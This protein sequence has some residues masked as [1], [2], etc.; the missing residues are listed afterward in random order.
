M[1]KS[2]KRGPVPDL[3]VSPA[4]EALRALAATPHADAELL[5][6]CDRLMVLWE[7]SHKRFRGDQRKWLAW[8]RETKPE[9]ERLEVLVA[10]TPART[11]DG[12][13]AKVELALATTP[14][15]K[16]DGVSIWCVPRSALIDALAGM[17]GWEDETAT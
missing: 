11:S 5:V 12:R 7:A 17:P 16:P 1:A 14:G 4:V 10:T 15:G 2:R 13:R 9:R 3:P 6:A 8:V